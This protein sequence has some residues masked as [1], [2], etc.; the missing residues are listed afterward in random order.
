MKTLPER[1]DYTLPDELIAQVP[2]DPRDAARLFVYNVR[3]DTITF[4]HFRDLADFLPEGALLVTNETK[5]VPA[6]T[7][8]EKPT[9]GMVEVL[10]LVNEG[11]HEDCVGCIA[12]KKLALGSVL[13]FPN[14]KELIVRKQEE[15]HFFLEPQFPYTELFTLLDR[16]GTTPIPKYI[17]HTPLSEPALRDRY[18]TIFAKQPASAA[19]PTA[20]LHFTGGVFR[21]LEEKK[22]HRIPVT[23]HV[24]LGT[25][26]PV[27]EEN[28]KEKHLH[29][30][31]FEIPDVSAR[32]LAA[33]KQEERTIVA[34]GTTVV[35]TLEST[36]EAILGGGEKAALAGATDLFIVPPFAFRMT[37]TLI[38]NF[39][40]PRSSL[41]M[42]VDAF[43]EHKGAKRRILDLYVVAVK[44]RFRFFSFGDAMLI[45]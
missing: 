2:A 36:A 38:T 34:V 11:F 30:E 40:V 17:K 28:I 42:L 23:L 8:L 26:A 3:T 16:Y 15:E 6:R 13:T 1:Y 9:G 43:L 39:H 18:Q 37:D 7:K 19:A 45:L 5:V 35:R 32:T 31:W 22:I 29:K 12:Q 33:A 44:E 14:G 24:G 20:S 41:M 10:F 25:F 4:A 27:R 21:S